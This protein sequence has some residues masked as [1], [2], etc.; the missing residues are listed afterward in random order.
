MKRLTVIR[1]S[2]LLAA[3]A[4]LLF[5]QA[6]KMLEAAR[7]KE[8]VEGDLKG[9]IE[10]YRKIA[11]QFARQPEVAAQALVKMG[12]CQEKMGQ[13][14]ARKSYERVVK[15]YAGAGQYA[16]Q[17]RVRLAALSGPRP[18]DGEMSLRALGS[19]TVFGVT[20]GVSSDGR[21]IAYPDYEKGGSPSVYDTVAK[22][23][24][25]LVKLDWDGPDGFG[26]QVAI[27]RDGKSA[28]F[29]WYLDGG[30]PTELRTVSTDGTGM[31]TVVKNRGWT[32]P[33]DWTADGR[34]V[35]ALLGYG[36]G[37]FELCLVDVKD[38][39][40]RVLKKYMIG[41]NSAR[42]SPDGRWI[43]YRASDGIAQLLS[44]DGSVDRQMFSEDPRAQFL[45]WTPDGR[46]IVYISERSG[47]RALWLSAVENGALTGEPQL[48]RSGMADGITPI[49]IAADGRLFFVEN[50]GLNNSYLLRLDG[51][52]ASRLTKR[53]EG[54][55]GFAAYSPDGRK[56]AWFGLKEQFQVG[57]GP[58]VIRN[59]ATG[60]EKSSPAPANS[61]RN[62]APE[63]LSDSRFLVFRVSE[64]G[65]DVLTKLDVETGESTKITDAK[66]VWNS[67]LSADGKTYYY[68]KQKEGPIVALNVATGEEKT[69]A[70]FVPGTFLRALTPSPDGKTL[71][72]AAQYRPVKTGASGSA[73]S[74]IELCDVATRQ[75]RA[76]VAAE[77]RDSLV[78]FFRRPLLFTPDGKALISTTN[79]AKPNR[80]RLFPLD[81]G[82]ARQ[83]VQSTGL[84]FDTSISPGGK[85]ITYTEGT[86]KSDLWVLE[87]YLPKTAR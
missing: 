78:G 67:Q 17:A 40:V 56:L 43:A 44:A 8:A 58:L 54:H 29:N 5:G 12:Q 47:G 49:G 32:T 34:F 4:G 10:Q 52:P 79:G 75:C 18:S 42:F 30:N 57:G 15:E 65:K 71:A 64:S 60:A 66:P 38:G 37:P 61:A 20:G 82:R 50:T 22:Q 7:Q 77:D 28:A 46:G 19:N 62:S 51:G 35:L 2:V 85:S 76:L 25:H 83:L 13:A 9:A 86:L 31:R 21:L 48:L 68:A 72:L 53:F 81:G 84:L 24:R 55:N 63:W 80:I 6:E 33:L 59:L 39:S 26:D 41:P 73:K 27:S 23:H 70:E 45:D 14:E 87:N 11:A 3:M 36:Q 69:V 1:V 16:A 74:A